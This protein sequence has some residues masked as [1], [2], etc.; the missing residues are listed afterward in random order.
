MLVAEAKSIVMEHHL[1]DH[2]IRHCEKVYKIAKQIGEKYAEKGQKIDLENLKAAALLHDLFR[3]ADI[4][5]KSYEELHTVADKYDQVTWDSL[6][7]RYK[8]K[9]HA[10]AAYEF[11]MNKGEEK[12]ALMIKKHYFYA[13]LDPT[14]KPSSLEEKIL[15]YADK[16]V[17]HDKIVSLKERF[18]EGSKR[19]NPNQKNR[20]EIQKI[21]NAYYALEKELLEPINLKPSDIK[22]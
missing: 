11:F 14:D 15:S 5:D 17:M 22:E 4:P 19:H 8:G 9:T 7:I 20:D 13:I 1:P 12:L 16:R 6:R 21:H 3:I 18:E 2:I 10:E